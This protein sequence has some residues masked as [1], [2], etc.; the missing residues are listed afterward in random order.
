M[1]EKAK[2]WCLAP[3]FEHQV[4]N[5]PF[6]SILRKVSW[7]IID[8]A[9]SIVKRNLWRVKGREQLPAPSYWARLD[10]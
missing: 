9:H 8:Y 5:R 1:R 4:S 7:V 2:R 3:I 10:L 6:I